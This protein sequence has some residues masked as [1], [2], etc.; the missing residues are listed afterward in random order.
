MP[1]ATARA[2]R[3]AP[4]PERRAQ[5]LAAA[6]ECFAAKGYHAST[7]DDLVRASGLSKGSL[8]WH[9][10]SKEDVFLAVFD[11]FAQATLADWEALLAEGCTALE[12]V[13]GVMQRSF[14]RLEQ[15]G[16][17]SL[18]AWAEFFAHPQARSRLA[19]LYVALRA[20]LGEALDRDAARGRLRDVPT[21]SAAAALTAA[22]EGLMLQAM[23]DAEFDARAHWPAVYVALC[24]GL[25]R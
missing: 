12:A 11:D 20:R 3:H 8:Y 6:F 15:M 2:R 25:E 1:E 17:H 18:A 19:D 14:A 10:R 13:D 16:P 21:E 7:M 9:F 24:H 22:G 23:V 4:A 5:I